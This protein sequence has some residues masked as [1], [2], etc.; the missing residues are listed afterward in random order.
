MHQ[1]P[2]AKPHPS[3]HDLDVR[4]V[5]VEAAVRHLTEDGRETADKLGKLSEAFAEMREALGNRLAKM[6]GGVA[7]LKWGLPVGLT[8]VTMILAYL[9]KTA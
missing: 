8:I 9:I 2:P 7:A 5:R 4:L 3:L 1:E 6:E